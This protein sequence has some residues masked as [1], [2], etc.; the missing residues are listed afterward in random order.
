MEGVF[1][2]VLVI[3]YV[4]DGVKVSDGVKV[5]VGVRVIVG[6]SV[7][8]GVK[9]I[10]GVSVMVEVCVMVSVDVSVGVKV[11]VGMESLTAPKNAPE[12]IIRWLV[13]RK[14]P[15][16]AAI[17]PWDARPCLR[18]DIN[19]NGASWF[20]LGW[21]SPRAFSSLDFASWALCSSTSLFA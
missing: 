10:V 2:G 13:I 20:I 7:M 16:N 11:A 21:I 4:R 19:V 8:V 6:V 15:N 9:V 1:V 17:M 3:V 12:P 18:K 5:L 14:T